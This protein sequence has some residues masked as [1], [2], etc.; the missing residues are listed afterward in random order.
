MKFVRA[1]IQHNEKKFGVGLIT[2]AVITQKFNLTK[3]R[4]NAI[5]E[6]I[7]RKGYITR[8]KGR[9]SC[10]WEVIHS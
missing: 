1:Y 5:G 6:A 2:Q 4:A 7:M 10:F 9:H 8:N 3:Q